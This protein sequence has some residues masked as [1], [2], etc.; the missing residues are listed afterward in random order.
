MIAEKTTEVMAA[1]IATNTALR[2][3]HGDDG[4]EMALS[5][6]VAALADQVYGDM[7]VRVRGAA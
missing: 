1:R 5:V 7:T 2:V 3:E 6:A 4:L